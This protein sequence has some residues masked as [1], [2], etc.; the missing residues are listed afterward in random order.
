MIRSTDA[1][2]LNNKLVTRVN[3]DS[4][5]T[6]WLRWFWLFIGLKSDI[7][8]PI[9]ESQDVVELSDLSSVLTTTEIFCGSLL[10]NESTSKSAKSPI[11]IL[12]IYLCI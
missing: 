8:F 6:I 12:P 4:S 5:K 10:L 7:K 2:D 1:T 9:E 3:T 11:L